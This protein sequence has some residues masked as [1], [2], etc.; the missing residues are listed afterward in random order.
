MGSPVSK[1]Q[2]NIAIGTAFS[3]LVKASLT[4][5]VGLAF[6]QVF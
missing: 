5:A 2:V 3:F 6:V 4:F 1:Q